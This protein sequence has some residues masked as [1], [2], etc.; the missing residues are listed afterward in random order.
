MIFFH[1]VLCGLQ[2]LCIPLKSSSHISTCPLV[3]IFDGRKS[4]VEVLDRKP[5]LSQRYFLL[6]QI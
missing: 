1:S 5:Q 3:I 6:S 2:V 4:N